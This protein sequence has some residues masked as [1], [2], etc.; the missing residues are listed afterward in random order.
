M[1]TERF[2]LFFTKPLLCS[3]QCRPLVSPSSSRSTRAGLS[4]SH[5]W[6]KNLS[7][8]RGRLRADS[9]LSNK[10]SP[11]ICSAIASR[12]WNSKGNLLGNLSSWRK[13][14]WW[15]A[16]QSFADPWPLLKTPCGTTTSRPT[17]LTAMASSLTPF[18][19]KTIFVTDKTKIPVLRTA[20][21]IFSAS[22][23]NSFKNVWPSGIEK[24]TF[25]ANPNQWLVVRILW[26]EFVR[27]TS[28][29][30][31]FVIFSLFNFIIWMRIFSLNFIWFQ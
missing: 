12:F 5:L 16:F 2:V 26:K 24:T 28:R 8:A 17:L 14:R 23:I 15:W 13:S 30:L 10:K 4:L 9:H 6:E 7:R 27:H 11:T 19:A 29:Y 21:K 20:K 1:R 31:F 22:G 3:A 18:A 25:V